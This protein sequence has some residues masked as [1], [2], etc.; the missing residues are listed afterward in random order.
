M[1]KN[2]Y[3]AVII[4]AGNVGAFY[5]A[6]DINNG[7]MT[8][9]H[10][11]KHEKRTE[12]V[13]FVDSDKN[14]AERAAKMWCTNYYANI[15]EMFKK[16]RPDI[17]SICVPDSV[18]KKIL[19]GCLE[20]KPKLVFCEKPLTTDI[21]SASCLVDEYLKAG[22]FLAVNFTRRWNRYMITLK[23]EIEENKYG[24]VLNIMGIYTKGILHNGSH[25]VDI[26]RYLFGEVR[27]ALVLGARV[28]WKK[29]DPALD[30]FLRFHN[31]YTAHIVPADER[32]YSIF[33]LD[34]LFEDGRFY[35]SE[36]GNRITYYKAIDSLNPKGYRELRLSDTKDIGLTGTILKAVENLINAVEGKEELLCS[37]VHA[38]A[39]QK[40]CCNLL[41]KYWSKKGALNWKN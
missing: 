18:H 38:L 16:E 2:R 26:L 27:D 34:L 9:A 6:P 5:S 15:H 19:E 21:E 32:K 33:D 31:G 36:F 23:K 35:L 40:V 20:Y 3:K 11:Y 39:T 12:L 41:E 14:K 4:G 24:N 22:I 13:A 29:N 30:A 7:I 28:D 17:V 37:G 8:H 25:L 1:A 10:A